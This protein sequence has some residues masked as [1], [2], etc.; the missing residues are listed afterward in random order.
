MHQQ[1]M[2]IGYPNLLEEERLVIQV[3]SQYVGDD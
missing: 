3:P 1:L 2:H